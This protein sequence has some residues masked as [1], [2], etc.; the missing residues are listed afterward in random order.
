MSSKDTANATNEKKP[1]TRT[2]WIIMAV[3]LVIIIIFIILIWVVFLPQLFKSSSVDLNVGIPPPHNCPPSNPPTN[4]VASEVVQTKP[5]VFLN[6]DPV[7]APTTAG[8][9]LLG[10]Y[11]YSSTFPGITETNKQRVTFTVVP[12]KKLTVLASGAVKAG[13]TY[14]F[15][16]TTLDTCGESKISEEISFTTNS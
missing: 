11:I 13:T 12:G 8:E 3:I 9:K 2:E 4:L 14:Y 16:V 1:T 10:Y 6:W 7:T 15:V 5:N